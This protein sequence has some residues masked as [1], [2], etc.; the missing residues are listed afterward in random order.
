MT[1]ISG[2]FDAGEGASL[3]EADWELMLQEL[4]DGVIG[5]PGSSALAVTATGTRGVSLATGNSLARAHWYKN[6]AAKTYFSDSN[7]A[8]SAR[9]DRLVQRVDRTANTVRSVLVKGTAGAGAPALTSTT[10]VTD[11]PLWRWTIAPGATAIS[12][13]VDER[14]WIGSLIRPC[15][16]GNRPSGPRPGQMAYETDTGRWIGYTGTT[17]KILHGDTDPVALPVSWTTVWV[18][19]GTM[20]AQILGGLIVGTVEVTRIGSTYSRLDSDGSLLTVLPPAVRPGKYR[21]WTA[22]ATG[23]S[24]SGGVTVRIMFNPTNGEVRLGAADA[25]IPVGRHIRFSFSIA[26]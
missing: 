12:G 19:A 15:T 5:V 25:D 11:R 17:W 4:V 9:V 13:L 6:T 20:E 7:P 24:T 26:P 10:T 3:T 1:E 16:S 8:G 18:S 14:Q 21:Y 2:P 22:Q 23:S